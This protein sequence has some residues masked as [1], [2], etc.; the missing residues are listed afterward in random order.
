M[1]TPNLFMAYAESVSHLKCAKH[2]NSMNPALLMEVKPVT[3]KVMFCSKLILLHALFTLLRHGKDGRFLLG[4]V[5][6]FGSLERPS[7][8]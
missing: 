5:A 6:D 3:R 8:Q 1:S 2:A 4:L 7:E